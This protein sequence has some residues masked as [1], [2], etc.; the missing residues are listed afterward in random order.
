MLNGSHSVHGVSEEGVTVASA[1][2]AE[3]LRIRPHDSPLLVRA[4]PGALHRAMP[5][6]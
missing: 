1:G 2:G 3:R 6:V 5:H 4:D